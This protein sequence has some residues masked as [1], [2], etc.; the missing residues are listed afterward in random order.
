MSEFGNQV[1]TE[2]TRQKRV[3]LWSAGILAFVGLSFLGLSLYAVMIL[4]EGVFDLSDLV[5]MPAAAFMFVISLIGLFLIWRGSYRLGTGLVFV[6]VLVPPVLAVLVFSN[7]WQI[8]LIYLL[9][10]TPIMIL[11]VLPKTVRNWA[12]I[13]A[14]IAAF[15]IGVIEI[16]EPSFRVTTSIAQGFSYALTALAFIGFLAFLSQTN[17]LSF[18]D[19]DVNEEE[20]LRN[21]DRV[22]LIVFL[23]ALVVSAFYL[24]LAW[25]IQAWQMYVLTVVTA[26]IS[27][28]SF[29]SKRMIRS[30]RLI[31][32]MWIV[33]IWMMAVFLLGV[34]LVDEVGIIVGILLPVLILV[35]SAQ[36][37]PADQSRRIRFVG[38]GVGATIILLDLLPLKYRLYV[39][40]VGTFMPVIV[41][42]FILT[43]IFFL[44]RRVWAERLQ[45]KLIISA[46]I[47]MILPLVI[48]SAIVSFQ[49]FNSQRSQALNEQ[50]LIAGSVAR[51][52]EYY[53]LE[54]VNELRTLTEVRGIEQLSTEEQ[55]NLLANLLSSQ[56]V[57]DELVLLDGNGQE[58]VYISRL[59]L[60]TGADLKNRTGQPEF[61]RPLE[62]SETYFG[63]V[64]FDEASGE[65]YEIVSLPLF[66]LRSGDLTNVLIARLRFKPVWELMEQPDV[67]GGAMVYMVD[68]NNRVVA[69]ANPSVALQA[70]MVNLPIEDGFTTGLD[71]TQV[72][73]AR[74]SIE[75]G[76]QSFAIVAEN[77][78][79]VA[80]AL[81]TGNLKITIFITLIAMVVASGVAMYSSRFI[82]N[83]ITDLAHAADAISTGDLDQRVNISPRDEIG[84]L[85][86]AFNSM[87]AQ[88]SG[89]IGSLEKQV[90]DRT[91]AVELSADVSRRL[92][93]ILD[94]EELV[95][96]V[97]DEV[98]SAFGYY[99]AQIYLVDKSS[100]NLVMV[101]GTGEA[102]R[103]MLERGHS[104]PQGMG[105]VGRAAINNQVVF[106]PNTTIDPNWL[107]NPLLPETTSEV[108][109]PIAIGEQVLGVLDV[110]HNTLEGLND[111]DVEILQSITHQVALA[112]RNTQL[113]GIAQR[114]VERETIINR[115]AQ[116]IQSAT[117]IDN[118]LQIA[119]RE[120][121]SALGAQHA[122]IQ[123]GGHPA[124][125]DR[126]G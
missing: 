30:G 16:L 81:A 2:E 20:Q 96:A 19:A 62:T 92:S 86:N 8:S 99:H 10:I 44:V 120:L 45:V 118:V 85:A 121:G 61:E 47:L 67:T 84:T 31:L 41:G 34:L 80:L 101:G 78:Q 36:T 35:T 93:T 59:S 65:P 3:G 54:R 83:P 6:A 33:S 1:T 40:E 114:Q 11:W 115:I 55:R 123:L 23:A 26:S 102:G 48:V 60:I 94:Q 106:V 43:M 71:G 4:Q 37:I 28:V 21:A 89:I 46:L 12:T 29:F 105:L 57:Y 64:N 66:D 76:D 53:I 77:P 49:T 24:L 111:Q 73:L 15:T 90:A 126:P 119:V 39:P 113:Y 14:L 74:T 122:G 7:F 116:Q 38:F 18:G 124:N 17:I 87:A 13:F 42:V 100:Q 110:Q 68:S 103:L 72:A 112:V 22:T 5:T 97:V 25:R 75:L 27:V 108:A 51:D 107:P 69:H 98:Q 63:P 9:L 82:T 104:I 109:V 88:L 117:T 32:G 56:D 58:K 79:E 70:L 50:R 125:G 95:R 52:V 91:R